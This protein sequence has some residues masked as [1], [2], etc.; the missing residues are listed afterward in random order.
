MNKFWKEYKKCD[1]FEERDKLK[2]IGIVKLLATK[3]DMIKVVKS[4]D[5]ELFEY[6]ILS[7]FQNVVNDILNKT[8]K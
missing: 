7:S 1:Y 4:M 3:K 5:D 2:E 6:F 8:D